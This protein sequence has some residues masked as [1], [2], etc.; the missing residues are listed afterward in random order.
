MRLYGLFSAAYPGNSAGAVVDHATRMPDELEMHARLGS[1]GE[2]FSIDDSSGRFT[3]W[4]AS[5]SAGDRSGNSSWWLSFN[6]LESDGQPICPSPTNRR[7]PASRDAGTPANGALADR[8]PRNEDRPIQG[9][10]T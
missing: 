6:R 9:S 10:T 3:G 4:Q 8:K 2:D 1:F 5:A 7:A